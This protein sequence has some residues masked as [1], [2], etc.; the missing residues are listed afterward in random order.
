[1]KVLF[2]TNIPAPY[3]I[4]FFNELGKLCN[5][6]V[7]FEGNSATD[8]NRN[9]QTEMSKHFTVVFLNGIRLGTDKFFSSSVLKLLHQKWDAIVICGY[10]T[11]TAMLA[12]EYMRLKKIPFFLEVDGGL[13][14]NDNPFKFG[15]K[16]HFISAADGWFSSGK[17]TIKYLVHYGATPEKIYEYP[18]SSLQKKDILPQLPT[19]AQKQVLR[20]QLGITEEK[21]LVSVG[22]FSYQRGY[23]KGY[24]MLMKAGEVLPRDVGIY[25]IGDEATEEFIQWRKIKN[26]THVHFIGFQSKENLQ[27]WYQAADV[28][29][30]P[31]REDIWGLVINEAMAQGLPIITTDKCVAG[32]ELVKEGENGCIIPA[33]DVKALEQAML[34]I[35]TQDCRKMGQKSLEFIKPYTIENMAQIHKEFL[36]KIGTPSKSI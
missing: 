3:R 17:E 19:P 14:H 23:G 10:S 5:L 27:K 29:V 8:R 26:L 30:L 16:K 4:A 6:T 34:K 9:W 20:Q 11:P 13:I 25:I 36:E 33:N 7:A 32:L 22:R 21:V 2:L 28:F 15:L 1:M 12:I 24:D 18:F 31:T 35:F